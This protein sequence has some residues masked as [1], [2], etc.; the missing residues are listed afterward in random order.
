M[1]NELWM[2]KYRPKTLDEFVWR[3]SSMRIKLEEYIKEGALPNLLF[4]GV[5]GTGKTSLAYLLLNELKIPSDDIL[6]IPASRV[7]G[8]P[9]FQDKIMGFIGAWALNPSGIKY[10]IL[11][12]FDRLTP[13]AMDFLRTEI[14]TYADTCRF[15]C[16]CNNEK[17]VSAALHSRFQEI[18][19]S[20]L[21]KEEFIMRVA[22][23]LISEDIEFDPDIL[24]LYMEKTYPDMRKCI[25]L[26]QHNIIA[27]VLNSPRTDDVA[28]H[29]YLLESIELFKKG[30][31]IEARTKII[32]N[33]NQDEYVE[34]Y[35][36][37]YQN[38]TLFG[39]NQEQWDEALVIIAKYL[40]RD[41]TVA[42]R[43]L[44]LAACFAEITSNWRQDV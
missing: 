43:E 21:D 28:I 13:T 30:N 12:E 36:F 40:Y 24:M 6:F 10:I 25:G 9:E 38:V 37:L 35:K 8:G 44:N 14:E 1:S 29:D 41:N 22:D 32:S 19:F 27:K 5:P 42:D 31:F 11:D 20:A 33:A 23:I 39:K 15:I 16:T 17:K 3:D 34:L 4:S 26:L 18:K 7:R 2:L